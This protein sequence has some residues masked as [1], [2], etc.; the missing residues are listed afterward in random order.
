MEHLILGGDDARLTCRNFVE[1]LIAVHAMF[2]AAKTPLQ[3]LHS[4]AAPSS[5]DVAGREAGPCTSPRR[6]R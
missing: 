1:A 6:L 3:P 4:I 5:W 2:M